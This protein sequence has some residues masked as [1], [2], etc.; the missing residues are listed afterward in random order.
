MKM[1]LSNCPLH[2]GQILFPQ[3]CMGIQSCITH[4]SYHNCLV[5]F[6]FKSLH[7]SPQIF[8]QLEGKKDKN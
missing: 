6:R 1:K 7:K 2:L 8:P 3:S 4:L 5:S